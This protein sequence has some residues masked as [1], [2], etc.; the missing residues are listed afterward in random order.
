MN[1]LPAY[2]SSV[3]RLS[4]R[5]LVELVQYYD[6]VFG[7]CDIIVGLDQQTFNARLDVLANVASL[8]ERVAVGYGE[9]YIESFAQGPMGKLSGKHAGEEGPEVRTH[10]RMYVFPQPVGPNNNKFDLSILTRWGP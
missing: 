3:C 10:S 8:G 9:R 2:V 4:P 7:R 1:A 5:E 6:A